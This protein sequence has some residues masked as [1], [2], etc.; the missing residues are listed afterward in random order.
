M[1][2]HIIC[3]LLL[4]AAACRTPPSA[5]PMRIIDL[6]G[7]LNRAEM[8]PA[9]T[10]TL[11][12]RS[13]VRAMTGPAPSRVIWTLPLPRRAVFRAMASVDGGAAARFRVGVS[14]DR[15]YEGLAAVQLVPGSGWTPIEADLS[16]YAGWKWS[17]FYQPEHRSW[18]L[19]LS[20]DAVGG[21]PATAVWGNPEIVSDA[22][23]AR[24]YA[25]RTRRR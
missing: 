15:I 10:F 21:T 23:A 17:L 8:R 19:V 3:I 24:E 9:D 1:P 5:P 4:L 13:G 12:D 7:E 14:D 25:R 16:A 18:R 22:D 2:R 6:I 11:S 20:A